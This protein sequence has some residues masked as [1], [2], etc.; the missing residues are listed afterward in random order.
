ME[1]QAFDLIRQGR[2]EEARAVLF[3]DEYEREKL[4]YAQGMTKF[5]LH[6]DIVLCLEQ[7]RGTII[8]L[9]EVLTMSARMAAATGNLRWE[10]RYRG[11]EPKLDAAIKEAM[12][13]AP[14]AYSGEAAAETDAA[15]I[16]LVNM[17]NQAFDL[18][19]QGRADKAKEVLFSDQYEKQKRVYVN[20]M[21]NFATGLSKTAATSREQEKQ[22]TLLILSSTILTI[23]VLFIS[24]L[25]I[26]RAIRKW[27]ANLRENNRR[28]ANQANE[29][30]EINK[31]LDRRVA[32]RTK[33]LGER[34]KELN[35]LYGISK[36]I[37]QPD[38]SRG[39]I[40]KGTVDL[41]PP[42][43]QYP[44]ITCARII[45]EGQEYKTQNFRETRCKQAS[46]ILVHGE[47]IGTVEVYY[48]EERPE[49]DEGSFLKEER[50]LIDSIARLLGSIT[51]R[52]QV[53]EEL[54]KAHQK[55][56][57]SSRLAGMA[58]VATDF[59]HNVG[60][61]LNSV[62]ISTILITEKL[63][64]SKIWNLKKVTDMIEDHIEDIAVFLT[65]DPQ[66]TH[67][68]AYLVK[69]TK[70]LIDEQ[71]VIAEK[72]RV[73]AG[74]VEHIKEIVNM[75]RA[76]SK[77]TGI[78]VT[79]SLEEVVENAIEINQ[80]GLEQHRIKVIR[81]FAEIGEVNIDKPRVMQIL[82]NLI[83]NAV[84]ALSESEKEE[85]MLTIRF[86][87]HG[88]DQLRIEVTDNGIGI[89]RENLTK[90]FRHG[91]TTKKYGHGFGLHNDALAAG[92][93]GGSLTV[94]SDGLG[95]GA[96]FRLELPFK[97]AGIT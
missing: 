15:N 95:K 70:L 23:P 47:Q 64:N 29:L 13:R 37:E 45:L 1:N 44:E 76:Y 34:V 53:E 82:V 12:K 36:L 75:H 87:K 19:R 56:V 9:D 14:R 30:A 86:Y 2:A 68:P 57:E 94:H 50:N 43:W 42:S 96:T 51:E 72:L 22:N 59:L 60:N 61:A 71:A 31:T 97:P 46:S 52:K 66:G 74:N 4:I 81:E 27:E 39:D 85:K 20:G 8:Y 10:E 49:S 24:L 92:E 26:F 90:I 84:Y 48:L 67:V 16:K 7:L 6:E 21:V 55:L 58:E 89:S 62:N 38:I 73:L 54:E 77:V 40:I 79:A 35:C 91:F 78:E 5:A 83:N 63:S 18:V 88:E 11:F 93:M 32:D 28:F 3:S 17:E 25:F 65:K 80:A 41:I 33:D 69:L